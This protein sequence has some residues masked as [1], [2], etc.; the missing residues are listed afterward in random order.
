M[1]AGTSNPL[2]TPA[3]PA[4]VSVSVR[5]L[6][7]A[8]AGVLLAVLIWSAN[9]VV[10]KASFAA[11]GPLTFTTIRY[12]VATATLFLVIRWRTG[13]IRWPGPVGWRLIGLGVMGFGGYQV[14]WT[15]GLTQIAV[16][17]SALLVAAAPVLT[18]LLAGAVGLDRLTRPKV[19]GAMTAF[20]GVAL[21]VAAGSGVSIGSSLA[22]DAI[23]LVAATLW[24]IYTVIGARM[25]RHVDPLQATAWSILGGTLFL[26]P[27]GAWELVTARPVA[28]SAAAV[29][30]IVYSG[31]LAA[32]IANVLVF[33][34]IRI[35][36]PTRA[37]ATQ[38]LVP[39]GAVALGAVFLA[40]QIRVGQVVGGL[41]IVLGLWLTR[42]PSVVPA[43]V[44]ARL[45][46]GW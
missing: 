8:E 11:L 32:G 6:R 31:S 27:F 14:L 18:A 45:E 35:V 28:I 10:V 3:R 1:S 4:G 22:G 34:A 9:F 40:E 41:V 19:A 20:A 43:V 46:A 44:R 37:S 15:L 2:T 30:G 29:L 33:R 23:T 12:L 17:D 21:V 42:R 25:L 39:A 7:L 13:A 16:G 5:E 26:V 24:A 38:F 36:G